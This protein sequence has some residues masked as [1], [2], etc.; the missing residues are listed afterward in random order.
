[1]STAAST[2]ACS[3]SRRM[4]IGMLYV[5]LGIVTRPQLFEA[6]VECARTRCTLPAA[7]A[8]LGYL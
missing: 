2:E 8:S 3:T 6:L 4:S 5:D 7:L 1:M